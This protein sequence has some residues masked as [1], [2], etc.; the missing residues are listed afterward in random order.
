MII[1]VCHVVK[2]ETSEVD[3]HSQHR[4]R[5]HFFLVLLDTWS[6]WFQRHLQLVFLIL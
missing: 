2:R 6:Q 1:P 3:Y 4:I 5:A